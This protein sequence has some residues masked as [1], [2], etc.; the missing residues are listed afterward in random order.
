M[1]IAERYPPTL[2]LAQTYS[3]HAPGMS[4]VGLFDRAFR[5]AERALTIRRS[6][7]DLWGQGQSLHFYG[8]AL[9]AASRYADAI[10]KCSEAV[11]LLERTGD[12]WE[13]NIARYHVGASLFRLGRLGEA[14][15][16]VR[17]VYESGMKLGD[18]Q[19]PGVSLDV[20]AR[21]SGGKVPAGIIE[22]EL[23][24][25]T[26]DVQRR[27]QV[28][29]A[30]AA[31]F[32]AENRPREA[33]A[34]LRQA[35]KVASDADVW[36]VYVYPAFS[37]LATALCKQAQQSS[38]L[39]PGLRAELLREASIVVRRAA[40]RLSFSKRIAARS[41]EKCAVVC[42]AGCAA[43]SR[44]QFDHGLAVADRQGRTL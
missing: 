13:I 2:E 20:W 28:L 44:Q 35:I 8:I 21:A 39:T 26:E 24:R 41:R 36:N 5:Y 42:H 40:H 1:N 33:A 18:Q 38:G 6:L 25:P 4:I 19:A 7:G 30:R 32:L 34:V 37:W 27:V 3:S 22:S 31:Q 17:T 11:T 29:Q 23:N 12:V 15:R 14:V 9:Y 10:A 43:R 16:E